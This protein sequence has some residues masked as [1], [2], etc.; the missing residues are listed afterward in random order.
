MPKY[1]DT[2]FQDTLKISQIAQIC[3]VHP[4]TVRR[5]IHKGYLPALQPPS[6][7]PFRVARKDFNAFLDRYTTREKEGA[8][9]EEDQEEGSGAV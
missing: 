9:E 8:Y 6:G 1:K 2:F 3:Q 7:K 5:W 4:V